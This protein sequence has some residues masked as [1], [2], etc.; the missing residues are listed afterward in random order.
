MEHS[1]LADVGG[2]CIN[3][4]QDVVEA[5]EGCPQRTYIRPK[6]EGNNSLLGS[7]FVIKNSH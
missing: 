3:F 6:I 5:N 1:T 4:C 7:N 2:S